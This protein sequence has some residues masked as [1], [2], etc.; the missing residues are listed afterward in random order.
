MKKPNNSRIRMRPV[1]E[2]LTGVPNEKTEVLQ[3]ASNA[4]TANTTALPVSD[5][6]LKKFINGGGTQKARSLVTKVNNKKSDSEY[7][8]FLIAISRIDL[9]KAGDILDKLPKKHGRKRADFTKEDYLRFA[10]KE[11][12]KRDSKTDPKILA[13]RLSNS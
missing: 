5:E 7:A 8:S 12:L 9:K 4:L 13:K 1:A 2:N 3:F 6:D 10:L 11:Q